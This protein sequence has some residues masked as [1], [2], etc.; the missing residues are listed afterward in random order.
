MQTHYTVSSARISIVIHSYIYALDN[1]M[2]TTEDITCTESLGF[3]FREGKI[4]IVVPSAVTRAMALGKS[5][6]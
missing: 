4:K 2:L 6:L 5:L 3:W 1:N